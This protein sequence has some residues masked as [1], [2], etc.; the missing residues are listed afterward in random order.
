MAGD[1]KKR[2]EISLS[3]SVLCAVSRFERAQRRAL[4]GGRWGR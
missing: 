4:M 2:D 3:K 1:L